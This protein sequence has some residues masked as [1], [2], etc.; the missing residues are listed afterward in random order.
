MIYKLIGKAVVRISIYWLRR[1]FV[2]RTALL[3]G[4]GVVAGTAV[5]G[6]AGYLLTRGD[7]PEA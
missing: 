4:A 2:L 6:V 3:A 7:V 1:K 5:V